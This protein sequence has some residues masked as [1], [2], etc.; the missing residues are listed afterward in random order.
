MSGRRG[1]G[2]GSIYQRESDNR[3]VG[4]VDLGYGADGKRKRKPIYGKTRKEVADKMK[5]VL[6]DQHIG[7]PI[8]TDE[9]GT[10]EAYLKAW[11]KTVKEEVRPATYIQYE[12]SVRCHLIP[13]LGHVQLTKLTPQH[14]RDFLAIEVEA[15]SSITT[16][17][18]ARAVLRRSLELAVEDGRI[19]RN[20]AK[21][22][23]QKGTSSPKPKFRGSYLSEDQARSLLA[24]LQGHRLEAL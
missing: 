7:K 4:M 2:E 14:I 20:P 15:G 13:R 6:H 23:R 3:W 22:I 9:R 16:A 17:K 24:S 1:K 19:Y 8:A 5:I 18:L 21:V 10:V 12:V 11:L